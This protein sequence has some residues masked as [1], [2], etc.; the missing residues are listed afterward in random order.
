M[1]LKKATGSSLREHY[2]ASDDDVDAQLL[3]VEKA[4]GGHFSGAN[5]GRLTI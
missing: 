1:I 2:T 3:E 5:V 4:G